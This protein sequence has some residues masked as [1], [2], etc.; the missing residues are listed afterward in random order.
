[1]SG[2]KKKERSKLTQERVKE[3]FDYCEDTGVL[4]RKIRHTGCVNIGDKVGCIDR[5]KFRVLAQVD[6]RKYSLDS[7]V[8]LWNKGYLPTNKLVFLDGDYRNTRIEN[9]KETCCSKDE[10]ILTQE[11]VREL[12]DYDC[13][14]GILT[15]TN[16]DPG[17]RSG[18]IAG[19]LGSSGYLVVCVNYK[20]YLVH[21]IIWLWMEGYLPEN[22]IDHINRDRLDNSWSNLREISP[23]CNTRNSTPVINRSSGV[24]GVRNRS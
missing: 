20:S 17:S 23:S 14:T 11:I 13:D 19:G 24:R 22:Q 5:T 7:L 1:M 8:W 4:I 2:L 18:C 3:L 9:L 10:N 6:G 15:R 21:R 16:F 12:F